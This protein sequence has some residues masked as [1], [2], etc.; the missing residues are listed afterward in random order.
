[1]ERL[2]VTVLTPERLGPWPADDYWTFE[3]ELVGA[4]R[5]ALKRKDIAG[6]IGVT[7][8]GCGPDGVILEEVQLLSSETGLPMT[9]LSLDEHSAEAGLV[10]RIEAF[11]DMLRG[12]KENTQ[13]KEELALPV[14]KCE[15]RHNQS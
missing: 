5:L 15:S 2:G 8:F 9:M 11:V 6:I 1:M 13:S 14:Q 3:Y 10:T 12:M 7:T 4:T